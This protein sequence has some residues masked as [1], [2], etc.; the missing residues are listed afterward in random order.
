MEHVT[1]AERSE[2]CE[3]GPRNAREF[4]TLRQ[5]HRESPLSLLKK[6]ALPTS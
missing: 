3:E 1:K 5:A 6:T 4:F 2:R